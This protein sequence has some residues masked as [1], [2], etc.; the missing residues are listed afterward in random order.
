M[1]LKPG[2]EELLVPLIALLTSSLL[3]ETKGRVLALGED[4]SLTYS[5]VSGRGSRGGNQELR[6]TSA[7]LAEEEAQESSDH[8][9]AGIRLLRAPLYQELRLQTLLGAML[10]AKVMAWE[11]FAFLTSYL[12]WLREVW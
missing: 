11:H 5:P 2:A 10:A 3:T 12:S 8:W 4:R 6:S 7:F 9:R 1:P